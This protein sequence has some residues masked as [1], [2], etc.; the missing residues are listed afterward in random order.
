MGQDFLQL[1]N[2]PAPQST[3]QINPKGQSSYIFTLARSLAVK[4]G[5]NLSQ[6]LAHMLQ[7]YLFRQYSKHG[8]KT[9]LLQ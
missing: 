9:Y 4:K 2:Q 8:W 6:G 3:F 5:T 7:I 1:L